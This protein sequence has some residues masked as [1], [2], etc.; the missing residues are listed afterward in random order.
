ML[1][2]GFS[3]TF[4]FKSC[5]FLMTAKP[6]TAVEAGLLAPYLLLIRPAKS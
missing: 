6:G 3:V 5:A 1:A 2:L 4:N